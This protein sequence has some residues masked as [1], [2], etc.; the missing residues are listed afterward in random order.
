MYIVTRKEFNV[1]VR[2]KYL[3]DLKYSGYIVNENE[4]T[5]T[6]TPYSSTLFHRQENYNTCFGS[7]Y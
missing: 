1:N 3:K 5:V 7:N 2:T 6:I 4:S